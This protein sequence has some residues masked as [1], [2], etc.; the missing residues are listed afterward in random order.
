MIKRIIFDVDDT[1]IPWRKEYIGVFGKVL[2]ELNIDYT[3]EDLEEIDR[4]VDTYENYYDMYDK[5][6]MV[7]LI[8]EK[9]KIKVPNNFTD[10]YIKHLCNCYNKEDKEV[11]SHT[12]DYLSK[13]Y[14]LVILSNWFSYS[15]IKR[16]EATEIDKYF[17]EMYFTDTIKNKPNKEAFD[18]ARGPYK[19]DECIMIGD[20]YKVDIQGAISVGIKAILIDPKDKY[21]YEN[22]IKNINELEELL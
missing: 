20:N 21:E 19:P 16:L 2:D 1:L 8:N 6:N 7:N 15:Q 5:Q 12:L 11:V 18:T 4:V 22:K 13:K 9:C 14:E 17:K 3:N 10:I